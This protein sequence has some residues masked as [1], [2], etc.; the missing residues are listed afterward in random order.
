MKKY[1]LAEIESRLKAEKV[2]AS[3]LEAFKDLRQKY[4]LLLIILLA[5]LTFFAI[6]GDEP[7]YI[8]A[9]FLLF[10]CWRWAV[11][12]QDEMIYLYTFGH[13]GEAEIIWIKKNRSLAPAMW[14]A[15]G[16][17]LK[18]KFHHDGE[19]FTS[20]ELNTNQN[21]INK[22]INED[23]IRIPILFDSENPFLNNYFTADYSKFNMKR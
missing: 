11:R 4:L 19:F 8:I 12:K 9:A 17:S 16:Y 20:C 14:F 22:R 15:P 7:L 13:K 3:K 10:W 5:A 23:S 18:Y 6:S 1:T 2:D 21:Q